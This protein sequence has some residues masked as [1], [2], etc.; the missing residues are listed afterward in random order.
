MA[1]L[2]TNN[3]LDISDFMQFDGVVDGFSQ[4]VVKQYVKKEVKN[5]VE[6][7]TRESSPGFL[8]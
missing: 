2:I 1:L 6:F 7:R 4:V 5:Q 3:W 8:W